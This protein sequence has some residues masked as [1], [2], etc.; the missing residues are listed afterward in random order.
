M[1]EDLAKAIKEK[2]VEKMLQLK[3]MLD[4]TD[5]QASYF[6]HGLT[7]YPSIDKVW[8]KYYQSDAEKKANDIPLNKTVWDVIEDKLYEY[9]D[10]PALEYFGKMF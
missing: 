1:Q 2:N 10:I 7:G 8:L 4:I 9:Y 3:Q 5:K 6:E